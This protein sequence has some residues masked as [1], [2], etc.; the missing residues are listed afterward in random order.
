VVVAERAEGYF[1][2]HELEGELRRQPPRSPLA[3]ALH[4]P[5]TNLTSP[6]E[7]SGVLL[8]TANIAWRKCLLRICRT[9]LLRTLPSSNMPIPVYISASPKAG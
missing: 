1:I 6:H 5:R 7:K 3:H 2:S 8:T 4:L 9:F